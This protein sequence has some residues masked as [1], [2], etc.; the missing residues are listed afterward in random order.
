M[1]TQRSLFV[2]LPALDD[3]VVEAARL[4]RGGDVVVDELAPLHH[5]ERVAD[6]R[7]RDVIVDVDGDQ[8]GTG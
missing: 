2:V 8:P 7:R 3:G 6:V 4:R 1:H 5:H